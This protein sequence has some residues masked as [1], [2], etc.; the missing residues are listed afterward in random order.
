VATRHE[1]A[2]MLAEAGL[3]DIHELEPAPGGWDAYQDRVGASARAWAELH[4]GEESDRFVAESEAWRRDHER[5]CE[6]L[7]WT[8][9]TARRP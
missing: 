5:D 7:T 2:T 8:V 3:R 9:W 4:P 6:F 1:Q